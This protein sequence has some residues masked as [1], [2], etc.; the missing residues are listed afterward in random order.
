MESESS[1]HKIDQ[2]RGYWDGFY[3]H[4]A[5]SVPTFPSQFAVF[6][7][8]NLSPVQ[9]VLE[10]GCGNGRDSAF[11]AGQGL[12]VMALDS[13]AQAMALCRSRQVAGVDYRQCDIE[14]CAENVREF[15]ADKTHIAVY[16]RFF[17]HAITDETE[18]RLLGTLC[19]LLPDGC[20]LYLEY[21]TREDAVGEKQFGQH[22]RRY[23]EHA[24]LLRQLEC[25]GLTVTYQVQ[26]RGFAT[27]RNEDAFIGRC[28]AVRCRDLS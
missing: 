19:D 8:S 15:L 28:V 13:S 20:A 26:G 27:Y 24:D 10:L 7:L 23:I 18:N 11:F 16:A 2:Q 14:F 6:M 9:G 17:L 25:H 12:P 21:R 1:I 3:R 5:D 4:S 22:Y